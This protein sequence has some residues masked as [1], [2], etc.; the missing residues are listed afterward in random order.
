MGD[1]DGF[2]LWW[3]IAFDLPPGAAP[4][5]LVHSVHYAPSG[6]G[7]DRGLTAHRAGSGTRRV[8]A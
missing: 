7:A 1:S 4:G 2:L 5:Q 8:H 3:N 6:L